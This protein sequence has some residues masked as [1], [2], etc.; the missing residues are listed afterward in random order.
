MDNCLDSTNVMESLDYL[1]Y[2][3]GPY[4]MESALFVNYFFMA[5]ATDFL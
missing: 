2:C 5:S 1:S 3:Y 4:S